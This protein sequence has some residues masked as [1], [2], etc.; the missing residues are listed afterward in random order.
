VAPLLR[1]LRVTGDARQ[2]PC[3]W[4]ELPSLRHL[5]LSRLR[6]AATVAWL[7]QLSQLTSL[8]IRD[9]SCDFGDKLS[10]D[11]HC[12]DLAPLLRLQR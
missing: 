7:A 4:P 10:N 2:P 12:F 6:G 11:E 8:V 3:F 1:R 5:E 9:C